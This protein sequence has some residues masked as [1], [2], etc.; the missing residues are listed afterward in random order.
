MGATTD[1]ANNKLDTILGYAAQGAGTYGDYVVDGTDTI[2]VTDKSDADNEV[3][4][5]AVTKIEFDLSIEIV[6]I[7]NSERVPAGS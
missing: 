7:S 4:Y 5:T 3:V 1:D 2:T 6:Q